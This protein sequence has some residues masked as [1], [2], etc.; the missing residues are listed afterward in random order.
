MCRNG[1]LNRFANGRSLM[2]LR[3]I[4]ANL[5]V[6]YFL[7][8]FELQQF[9]CALT[10]LCYSNNSRLFSVTRTL[11]EESLNWESLSKFWLCHLNQFWWIS[12]YL[13]FNRNIWYYAATA[14]SRTSEN[15]KNNG[16][17]EETASNL[18]SF[19][20]LSPPFTPKCFSLSTG[21]APFLE[22]LRSA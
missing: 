5:I 7:L 4:V 14:L 22:A 18:L 17:H 19:K 20:C 16:P 10:K 13:C 3:L 11:L 9:A 6:T 2:K 8:S 15:C 1:A 21:S 12:N